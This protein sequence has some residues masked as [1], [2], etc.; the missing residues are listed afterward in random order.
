M[1]PKPWTTQEIATAPLV[2]APDGSAVRVLCAT[3]RGS[4]ISFSLPPGAVSKAVR[5]RTVEEIWYVAAGQ[6]RLWRR[7]GAA[8]E[9][10]GLAPGLSLTIP[11]GASFQFRNDGNAPLQIVAVTMPPW[12]GADEAVTADGHWP[13]TI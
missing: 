4:M 10:L 8:E 7:Q 6:G 3:A 12:P 5:H 13:A 9:T 11:V 2:E 1:T